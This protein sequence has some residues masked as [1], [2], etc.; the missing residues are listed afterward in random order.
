MSSALAV[1]AVEAQVT[2]P[3]AVYAALVEALALIRL[4]ISLLL[5]AR[6]IH[7]Q[8]ERVALAIPLP[9]LAVAAQT[10]ATQHLLSA[11]QLLPLGL[12]L[13]AVVAQVAQQAFP[14][15]QAALLQEATSI[16][17][18]VAE[19]PLR[20]VGF[21]VLVAIVFLVAA[22]GVSIFLQLEKTRPDTAGV[23]A[24]VVVRPPAMAAMA[25]LA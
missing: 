24:A 25:A 6:H 5:L 23:G 1:E 22:A 7:M 8:L 10:A 20:T 19:G 12:G 9:E 4:D 13:A 17:A 15:A 14:Q 18:A 3:M 16:Q 2:I 11:L 21:L